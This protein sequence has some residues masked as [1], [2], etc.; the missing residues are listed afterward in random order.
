MNISQNRC[1]FAKAMFNVQD[2]RLNVLIS[3]PATL[4]SWLFILQKYKKYGKV[5]IIGAGSVVQLLPIKSLKTA[6]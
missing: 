5:L 1:I 4:D 6:K 2:S 3:Q